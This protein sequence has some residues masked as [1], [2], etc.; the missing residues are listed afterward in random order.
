MMKNRPE[1]ERMKRRYE[2]LKKEIQKIGPLLKGN[3]SKRYFMRP[4]PQDPKKKKR[5]GPNYHWTWKRE[6]KT[7]TVYL[8]DQQV[9]IYSK[10]IENYKRLKNIVIEMERI[11]FK[12]LEASTNSKRRRDFFP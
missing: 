5:S 2:R 12:I 4:D 11:S 10:A 9:P 8:R 6:G 3:I 1:I 7:V